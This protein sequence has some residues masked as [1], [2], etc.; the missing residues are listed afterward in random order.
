MTVSEPD[1]LRGLREPVRVWDDVAS[2]RARYG[3]ERTEGDEFV[4]RRDGIAVQVELKTHAST[5]GREDV[6]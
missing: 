1:D 2:D 3:E 6:V 4:L 5:G